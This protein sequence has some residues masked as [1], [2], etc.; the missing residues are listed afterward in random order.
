[1]SRASDSSSS[2][3]Q[4]RG[5]AAYPSGTPPYG[6]GPDADPAAAAAKPGEPKTETTLTTRIR[7]NIPGSRPIP[8]VVMRTPL[9]DEAPAAEA[10]PADAPAPAPASDRKEGLPTRPKRSDRRAPGAAPPG[11]EPGSGDKPSDWFAPRKAGGAPPPPPAAARRQQAKGGGQQAK[12]GGKQ[13]PPLP[14]RGGGQNPPAGGGAGMAAGAGMGGNAGAGGGV[15]QDAPRADQLPQPPAPP[16]SGGA[17]TGG[18]A[19]WPNDPSTTAAMPQPPLPG[20]GAM[21]GG[22]PMNGGAPVPGGA[23]AAG[24]DDWPGASGAPGN[25]WPN[26][27]STTGA[28]P[29]PP[30]PGDPSTTAATP[31]SNDPSTTA[32]TPWPNDPSTTAS[33]PQPPVDDWPVTPSAGGGQAAGAS[34]PGGAP[35]KRRRGGDD[36]PG[37]APAAGGAAAPGGDSAQANARAAAAQQFP[38]PTIGGMPAG[39]AAFAPGRT[40]TPREGTPVVRSGGGQPGAKGKKKRGAKAPAPAGSPQASGERLVSGVPPVSPAAGQVPKP[41]ADGGAPRV[42]VPK[43]KPGPAVPKPPAAATAPKPPAKGAKAAKSAPKKK[44][45]NKLVLLGGGLVAL[46]GVAY[47]AGLLLDHA[48]VPNGTTVLGVDIGGTSKEQAV[49][50]LDSALGNRATAPLKVSIGGKTADLKPSVAGLSIDTQAT[51][52]A[53]AVKD[54]NPVTVLGS[55]VGGTRTAEPTVTVDEEKVAAALK[56]LAGESGG[57]KEGTIKFQPGK[58]VAV[59]GQPYEGIDVD[60]SVKTISKA[61]RDRA[62]TGQDKPVTLA[63][64]AQQPKIS[65][66]EVDRKMKEFA[67]PAMS[68]LVTVQTDPAHKIQ[69]GPDRSLPKILSV[70]EVNGQLVENYDLDALKELYGAAFNGVLIQRGSGE[71]KPVMPQDVANALNKALRGKTPAERVGV[72]PLS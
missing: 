50:K 3:P 61:Y 45:R 47:A 24:V 30:L 54:Y 31:W 23:P 5:G 52:R 43:P 42:P 18:G 63:T 33:M 13:Q 8:P 16:V 32:A 57:A 37:G 56:T 64:S 29:Q 27:P 6:T 53:A 7:I 10:A 60:G 26:D 39:G 21:Q 9:G 67:E 51:V 19:P 72:I 11:M 12:G 40:D 55:L 34:A 48:D 65:K 4:G 36:W 62:A 46:V 49:Q 20:A 71:K 41:G 14:R 28:M 22:A 69:F 35:T 17:P 59:Y 44:G 1:M 38:P 70:K 66:A 58:A 68:G 15:W 2:G 25:A